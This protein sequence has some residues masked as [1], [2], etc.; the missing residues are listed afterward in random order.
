MSRNLDGR[1]SLAGLDSWIT[2][3]EPQ[4][5]EPPV[6]GPDELE[7]VYEDL[8]TLRT[9]I[10]NCHVSMEED[11]EYI[12]GRLVDLTQYQLTFSKRGFWA[13]MDAIGI[14]Q[15]PGQRDFDAFKAATTRGKS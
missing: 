2:R 5:G 11:G 10:L 7:L 15:K 1:D 3:E 8:H 4:H 12:E 6:D 9:A 14:E 13:L